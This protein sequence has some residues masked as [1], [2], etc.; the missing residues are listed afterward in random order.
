MKN[1]I[2]VRNM[3][4]KDV[5]RTYDAFILRLIN[6]SLLY[7]SL[8]RH[9]HKNKYFDAYLYKAIALGITSS[10]SIAL[11]VLLRQNIK[12]LNKFIHISIHMIIT[13]ALNYWQLTWK[14]LTEYRVMPKSIILFQF[15]STGCLSG[16]Q[17]CKSHL[18]LKG[19]PL[20]A[21]S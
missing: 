1:Q 3:A 12:T 16:K 19:F 20:Y 8:Y 11:T 4:F 21:R 14:F 6:I 7:R 10:L 13:C 2:A 17:S 18:P 15:V 5:S 9:S